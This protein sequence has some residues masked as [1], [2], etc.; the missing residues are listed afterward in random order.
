MRWLDQQ[1]MVLK[2]SEETVHVENTAHMAAAAAA[3]SIANKPESS[4]C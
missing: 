3:A 2:D 1:W 4:E